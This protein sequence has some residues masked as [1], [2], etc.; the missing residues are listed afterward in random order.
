[1]TQ[2]ELKKIVPAP[3]YKIGDCVI[4]TSETDK[5]KLILGTVR[6]ADFTGICWFYSIDAINPTEVEPERIHTYEHN[7]GS[8]VTKI[9]TPTT[10]ELL[11]LENQK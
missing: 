9:V 10:E 2:E 3:K 1:M 5:E 8:A 7:T 6:C 11:E 4:V